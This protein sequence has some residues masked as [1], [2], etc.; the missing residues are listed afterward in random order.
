MTLRESPKNKS[1]FFLF[2]NIGPSQKT[3]VVP[4]QAKMRANPPSKQVDQSMDGSSLKA[5]RAC[6]TPLELW[7][8]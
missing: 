1:D 7:L 2:E 6:G 4:C 3:R 8:G 5:L